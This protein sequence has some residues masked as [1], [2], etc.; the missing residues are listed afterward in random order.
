M[1][2]PDSGD[3]MHQHF[4]ILIAFASV[5]FPLASAA[6]DAPKSFVEEAHRALAPA[7]E[8]RVRKRVSPTTLA[9]FRSEKRGDEFYDCT[10]YGDHSVKC[11]TE[12]K[13]FW[14]KLDP[15]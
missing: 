1:I 8:P 2:A 5:M 4:V 10:V 14:T 6:Q 3:P 13:A 11:S 7:P 12:D 9:V 15:E